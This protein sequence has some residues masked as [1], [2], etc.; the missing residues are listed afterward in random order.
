MW[1]IELY[2]LSLNGDK[3]GQVC[4]TYSVYD[5]CFHSTIF[6]EQGEYHHCALVHSPITMSAWVGLGLYNNIKPRI[7]KKCLGKFSFPSASQMVLGWLV[8]MAY[9]GKSMYKD[10]HNRF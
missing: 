9:M 8:D 6:L 10:Y 7:S 2:G 1:D 3:L 4:Y 5:A